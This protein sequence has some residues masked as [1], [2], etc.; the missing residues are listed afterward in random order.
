MLLYYYAITLHSTFCFLAKCISYGYVLPEFTR[1]R[2][3]YNGP[4]NGSN[5]WQIVYSC[6]SEARARTYELCYR[7][8]S[9]Y[10]RQSHFLFYEVYLTRITLI[11]GFIS[12]SSTWS[13]E[14][15]G[16]SFRDYI[17]NSMKLTTDNPDERVFQ[18]RSFPLVKVKIFQ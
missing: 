11:E 4:F 13:A 5:C 1:C 15:P 10:Q 7:S 18:I 9:F 16:F 12:C 3:Y 8:F 14:C 6:C 2:E 17:G